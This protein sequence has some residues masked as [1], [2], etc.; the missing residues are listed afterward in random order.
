[1]AKIIEEDKD[2]VKLLNS[3]N[4]NYT[5]FVP[6][7]IAFK[8]KPKHV[9]NLSKEVLKDIILYHITPGLYPALRLVFGH[10]A[11]TSLELKTLGGNPQRVLTKWLGFHHGLKLNYYSSVLAPNIVRV[12]FTIRLPY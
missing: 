8:R 3:T 6:T 5:V 11:P 1:V 10:T 2:L 4:A 7:D 12:S 9:P